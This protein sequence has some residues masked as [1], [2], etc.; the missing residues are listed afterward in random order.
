MW[1]RILRVFIISTAYIL[2][3]YF[4]LSFVDM[5]RRLDKLE[6][7]PVIRIEIP[8]FRRPGFRDLKDST[9]DGYKQLE[10]GRGI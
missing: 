7:E 3:V 9:K 10:H 5:Q 1:H 6:D 2:G 8:E 4:A